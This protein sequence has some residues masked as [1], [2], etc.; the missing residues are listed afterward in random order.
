MWLVPKVGLVLQGSM[1]ALN[2]SFGKIKPD[3][4][5]TNRSISLS[6]S[7][8]ILLFFHGVLFLAILFMSLYVYFI[9]AL[10]MSCL[11]SSSFVCLFL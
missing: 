9:L 4:K 3:N 11:F 2:Q 1:D 6:L 10:N 8:V 5:P 7:V